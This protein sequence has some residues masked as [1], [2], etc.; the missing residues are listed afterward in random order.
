MTDKEL[1]DW[2]NRGLW[3]DDFHKHFAG[4]DRWD[5]IDVSR[6]SIRVYNVMFDEEIEEFSPLEGIIEATAAQAQS[7]AFSMMAAAIGV[8]AQDLRSAIFEYSEDQDN[9]PPPISIE[10]LMDLVG[11]M[12]AER[13]KRESASTPHETP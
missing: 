5:W 12:K 9:L 13:E 3:A 6:E 2:E 7:G 8:N 10:K 4:F 11:V 1:R